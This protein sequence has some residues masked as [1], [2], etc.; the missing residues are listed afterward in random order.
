[1][2]GLAAATKINSQLQQRSLPGINFID[3]LN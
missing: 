2:S 1:V 3:L